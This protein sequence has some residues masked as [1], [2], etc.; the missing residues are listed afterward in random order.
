MSSVQNAKKSNANAKNAKNS[1]AEK[2]AKTAADLEKQRAEFEKI[3]AELAK[4]LRNYTVQLANEKHAN[5]YIEIYS[6]TGSKTLVLRQTAQKALQ[7]M[8]DFK[9]LPRIS[10]KNFDIFETYCKA[11]EFC[12]G[13]I[14]GVDKIK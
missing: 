10:N 13:C 2:L 8:F 5:Y 14:R 3:R 9:P 7:Q 12:D 1:D 4:Q 11:C 6:Q